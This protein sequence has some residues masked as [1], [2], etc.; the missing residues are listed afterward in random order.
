[1]WD[2]TLYWRPILSTQE[3]RNYA[4]AQHLALS[5]RAA[6]VTAFASRAHITQSPWRSR[7]KPVCPKTRSSVNR[8]M[9]DPNTSG[10]SRL[11]LAVEWLTLLLSREVPWSKLGQQTG[12]PDRFSRGLLSPSSQM[13]GKTLNLATT[14]SFPILSNSSFPYHPFIHRYMV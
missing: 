5:F 13:L 2:I 3:Q 7:E 8:S 9:F 4:C 12:Y 11:K 6:Y 14:A 1:V 10:M